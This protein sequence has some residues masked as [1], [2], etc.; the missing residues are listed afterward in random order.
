M[1]VISL[2]TISLRIL[3]RAFLAGL[4]AAAAVGT[5]GAQAPAQIRVGMAS[6][7][8]VALPVWAAMTLGLD[9]TENIV[10]VPERMN[11]TLTI[12]SLIAGKVDTMASSAELAIAKGAKL[13][14]VAGGFRARGWNGLYA[15]KKSGIT[16]L[17]ELKGR[18]IGINKYGDPQFVMV[19]LALQRAGLAVSDITFM[20]QSPPQRAQSLVAG[21][22]D[23][24]VMFPPYSSGMLKQNAVVEISD[25]SFTRD[26]Q[27]NA[28]AMTE[29]FIAE[30]PDVVARF[31][32]VISKAVIAIYDDANWP[33][34]DKT[35]YGFMNF[36]PEQ[37][38]L[39]EYLRASKATKILNEYPTRELMQGNIFYLE[40]L[41]E[42]A[43][44]P[45]KLGV[46]DLMHVVPEFKEK[47]EGRVAAVGAN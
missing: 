27:S 20:Y 44:G 15:S 31:A 33:A 19:E 8:G 18:R 43:T 5:A 13:R 10:F 47:F 46:D 25:L 3:S 39:R 2:R 21:A 7:T 38:D 16:S 32:R 42:Y 4:V 41:P 23:A 12:P 11:T 24:G 29:S 40:K 34:F 36:T 17:K 1:N 14:I 30:R 9:K 26:Y 6:P 45:R 22:L 28:F 35:F 37:F